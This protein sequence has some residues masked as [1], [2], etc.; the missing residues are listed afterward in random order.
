M[1]R[2]IAAAC[3]AVIGLALVTSSSVLAHE[4]HPHK[5]MGTVTMAAPDHVM[6]K[7]TDGKDATVQI[8]SETK[9]VKGK[10]PMKVDDLK[11]GTRVVI[12]AVTEKTVMKAK[13][14]EIGAAAATK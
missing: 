3:I 9:I 12:T 7:T 6:M 14:I 11:A 8:T 2:R 5:M 1:T 4:G 13:T 10:E